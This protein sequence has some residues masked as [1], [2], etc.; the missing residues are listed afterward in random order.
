MLI[1]KDVQLHAVWIYYSYLEFYVSY[2]SPIRQQNNT[3]DKINQLT[4]STGNYISFLIYTL[5]TLLKHVA[6]KNKAF[7]IIL[8]ID[9]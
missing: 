5:G 7:A 6:D 4:D 3:I 1:F 8:N 2:Y 9:S